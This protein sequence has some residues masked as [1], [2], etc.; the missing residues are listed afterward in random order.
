MFLVHCYFVLV[1]HSTGLSCKSAHLLLQPVISSTPGA[2][3]QLILRNSPCA[4]L[5]CVQ[6]GCRPQ[7]HASDTAARGKLFISSPSQHWLDTAACRLKYQLALP[8]VQV[9]VLK[10]VI[11]CHSA[12]GMKQ[13]EFENRIPPWLVL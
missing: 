6:A 10:P 7:G 12:A 9:S 3:T 13:A 8:C 5:P 4:G 1:A 11:L 2:C